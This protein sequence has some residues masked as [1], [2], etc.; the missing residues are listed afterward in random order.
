MAQ[1]VE[2]Q[3]VMPAW[4]G[5]RSLQ[6]ILPS[7]G[8]LVLHA[9]PPFRDAQELPAAIR[10]S[11]LIGILYEG[12]A[13]N[14]QEAQALLDAGGVQLAPA[15]DYGVVVPLA[16]VVTPSMYLIE[17]SD[18]NRP[19]SKKYSVLNEGMQWCT[20]LGIFA[21]EMVP[22]LRW[23]HQDLGARLAAQFQG[24][25]DLAPIVQASL[26]NGDDGHARTMHGSRQLADIIVSW[27]INDEASQSFLYGAMAWALNYWMAAS[28]LILANQ[29]PADGVDAIV[30]VGG[31]GLRFGLQLASSTTWLVTDAPVIAGNKEPGNEQAQALGALGDS[32]VVDFVGLGG[33]CLDLA[34]ISARNLHA[35][36]P[37]D[38]LTRQ[39]LFLKTRLPFLA[40][41]NG[42]SD[43]AQVIANNTGPLVLLGMIDGAGERG[44]VGG[45]VA[46]VD[47]SL[48]QALKEW[49]HETTVV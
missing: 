14:K 9:G 45:G 4:T 18:S 38:Y 26:L 48:L 29:T 27:G 2:T 13:D 7:Q 34:G 11:A 44:R 21:D 16:G 35:F 41:R 49:Q 23:L 40:G 36:L 25:V 30:K 32:A 33:Q 10:N 24:P 17:V 39:S 37:S 22:H 8:R 28:A 46:T 1:H 47:A 3:A 42:I 6:S 31:N 19:G 15:Q 5:V 12:W 43:F 20:R